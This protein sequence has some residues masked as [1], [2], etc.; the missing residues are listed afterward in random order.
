MP[1]I[2]K[3]IAPVL[4][5]MALLALVPSAASAQDEDQSGTATVT[6]ALILQGDAPA[7]EQFNLSYSV[8]AR[9]GAQQFQGRVFCGSH[10]GYTSEKARKC[11]SMGDAYVITMQ[12]PVGTTVNYE[13]SRTSADHRVSGTIFKGARKVAGDLTVSHDYTFGNDGEALPGS[14]PD[15]GAGGAAW[16]GLPVGCVIALF[17]VVAAACAHAQRREQSQ[18][19]KR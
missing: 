8:A 3:L 7:G 11:T 19:E 9:G 17:A 10:D 16:G 14:L 2:S 1:R 12:A 4:L 15:T 5:A 13:Y 18:T 6:F